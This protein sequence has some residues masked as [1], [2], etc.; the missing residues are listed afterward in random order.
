MKYVRLVLITQE[1]LA[2]KVIELIIEMFGNKNITNK[3]IYRNKLIDAVR[4][5]VIFNTGKQEC[6]VCNKSKIIKLY[7]VI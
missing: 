2:T 6:E 1:V 7:I 4:I 3:Q 5:S